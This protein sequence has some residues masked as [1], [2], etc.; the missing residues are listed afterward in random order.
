MIHNM[1][2]M[3]LKLREEMGISQE[4]LG[5]GLTDSV[6]MSRLENGGKETDRFLLE[7]LFQRLGKSVDKFE[8]AVSQEEYR[9][10]ILRSF[11][12]ENFV[13]KDY[14][15]TAMLLEEYKDQ[16]NSKKPLHRQFVLAMKSLLEYMVKGDVVLC[17]QEL[18]RALE[19]TFPEWRQGNLLNCYLC[20]QEIQVL[21]LLL[22][23]SLETEGRKETRTR[24]EEL[25][26]YLEKKYTDPE[27]LSEVYP[28]CAW[29]LAKACYAGA[30]Y[31]LAYEVCCCGIRCIVENGILTMA[32]QLLELQNL[33]LQKIGNEKEADRVEKVYQAILLLYELAEARVPDAISCILSTA[34]REELLINRELLKDMRLAQG[35]S[36]ETLS[37]DICS[38]ET[39]SRIE[40]GKRKPNRKNLYKMY[41]K[42]SLDRENYYGY[43]Q[44]DNFELYEKAY[45][46]KRKWLQGTTE[47]TVT[48]LDEL[49]K[50]LDMA[51]AVNKQ[52]IESCKLLLAVRNKEIDDKTAI[53]EATRIL[54]YTLKDYHGVVYRVPFREECVL[55]NQIA[56]CLKHIGREEEA[57]RL[58]EQVL[59]KFHS[60]VVAERHH[61]VSEVLIYSNYPGTLEDCNYLEKSEKEALSGIK[62]VLQ[63]QRGDAAAAILANLS[64]VYAKREFQG[65]MELCKKY[66]RNSIYLLSFYLCERESNTMCD[67]YNRMFGALFSQ[68]EKYSW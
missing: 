61:I 18:S 54:Q 25:F 53:R 12:I 50:K 13:D 30:D 8:M 47:E 64:F 36:Q 5:R 56:L 44:A 34:G 22:L 59:D 51:V 26:Y 27:C 9:L 29:L 42:M 15:M 14:A 3:I 23:V 17:S 21:L 1:G 67:H 58:W 55:L 10:I 4:Q 20:V 16:S 33:C 35:L 7:A 63:C 43:I 31:G 66:M 45:Q 19:V 28:Q 46:L 38:W 41:K 24:L 40:T 68:K 49:E 65:A 48:L 39:L 6:E 52:F 37:E 60:S 57:L 2:N 62:L 32:V 11:I